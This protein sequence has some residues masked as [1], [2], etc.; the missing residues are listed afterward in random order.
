MTG[1]VVS[2]DWLADHLAEVGVLG[3]TYVLPPDPARSQAEFRDA[4]IPVARLFEIDEVADHDHPLP[5]MMP[6]PATFS[7][8][9][10]ALGI[11]GS[12]RAVVYDR[13]HNHFRAPHVW[14]TCRPSGLP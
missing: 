1:P 6:D 13:S 10:A 8:E 5:H 9:M 7:Q 2:A 11:D 12:K 14:F 4:H 3:A